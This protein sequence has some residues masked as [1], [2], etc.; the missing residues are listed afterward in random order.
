MFN[1]KNVYDAILKPK[2]E[3][4]F[5]VG[6]VYSLEPFKVILDGDTVAIP[7][8][9]LTGL[10]G[11]DTGRRV[12]LLR[13]GKQFIAVG[14]IGEPL[15]EKMTVDDGVHG[16]HAVVIGSGQNENGYWRRWSDGWQFCWGVV[17]VT[18][19]VDTATGS[20]YRSGD[21][22]TWTFPKPFIE[23]GGFAWFETNSIYRWPQKT[24]GTHP[25]EASFHLFRPNASSYLGSVHGFA[26]GWW[27]E[28]EF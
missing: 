9:S 16:L 14:V 26:V 8:Q 22:S 25:T 1:K 11:L 10:L 12:V 19:P 28:P 6:T 2:Q 7:C 4:Q 18:S 23:P 21:T 24:S 20:M 5:T 15:H 17:P 27:K 3:R 13:Y